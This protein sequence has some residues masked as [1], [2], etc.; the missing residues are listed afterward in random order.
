MDL[1]VFKDQDAI[2]NNFMGVERMLREELAAARRDA[3]NPELPGERQ[4]Q[5]LIQIPQLE[6]FLK[7]LAPPI[8]RGEQ[9]YRSLPVGAPF[10][11]YN[12]ETQTYVKKTRQRIPGEQ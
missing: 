11:I 9:E 6:D 1:S 3:V 5:A 10:L 8:V 4:K 12:P 7:I 2:R